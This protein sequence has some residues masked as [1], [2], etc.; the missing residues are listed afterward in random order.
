[1]KPITHHFLALPIFIAC[2]LASTAFAQGTRADYER[3][4]S[5]TRRT[6]GKLFKES[7]APHWLP[8]NNAFWYRNDLAGGAR[9]FILVEAAKG[10]RRP[11]FD[12]ARLATA[13]AAASGREVKS[14]RLPFDALEFGGGRDTVSFH[15]FGK[16]WRCVLAK[17]EVTAAPPAPAAPLPPPSSGDKPRVSRAST[18][19]TSLTFVNQTAGEI[20]LFWID[21][22]GQRRSYGR[23]PA[24]ERRDQHS[25]IGHVWRVETHDGQL[26]GV[27]AAGAKGREAII[28]PAIAAAAAVATTPAAPAKPR[29]ADT[30]PDGRWQAFIKN[31]NL[32]ARVLETKEEFALTTDG[33]AED[34]YEAR[35]HWSPDS[36]RLA[37][38]QIRKGEER[39]IT[40]VESSPKE[41]LQP[42]LH[43]LNYAKP[44]DRIAQPRPRLFDL[45]NRKAIAIADTLFPNPF[46]LHELH[47]SPDSRWF[48][49]SYNQRGHQVYRIV[50]IDA[51]TGAARALVNEE[52]A[53]FFAYSAKRH[54]HWLDA[55]GELIWMSERDGWNHLYRYETATGRVK[56]AITRGEWVVRGVERVDAERGQVWFRA[57]G[58]RPG[59]DPYQVHLCRVN[60][61]GSG[62]TVLTE[63]D[64]NHDWQF[65]PDHRFVLDRWSRVDQ[66]PVHELRD[67]ESGRLLCELE[68]ADAS[69]LYKTGWRAPERFVAKGRDGA[70]DIFGIIIRPA[71]FD[72][73]KKYPVIEEIYAGPHGA[74]VPKTFGRNLRPSG[75]AELGFILVRSD[76]MGTN[77]RSKQFHDV[78][79]KNLGDSGFPDRIAW[80]KA[81]AAKHPELDLTRVGIYG[82]SAGGQSTARALFAHGD[83][84]RVGVADCGCHD[85]R[86]DKIWWNEQWMGWPVGPHYA[87]QSNV[88]G[89]KNLVG[90]LLLIVGELDKNVDPSSTMQVVNALIKADKDFDLLV[91]PGGGHGIAESPYGSRRRVDFFVRHL[92]GVEPRSQP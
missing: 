70:T 87:E 42:K 65:S 58:I 69:E 12:H 23:V 68:R 40:L 91:V 6:E 75:M 67:A 24:G 16:P 89:A 3:A 39:Q 81:A 62:L 71:N 1:M 73:T 83:F 27:F 26:L 54:L 14:E 74:F 72:P 33:A 60:F 49:F 28:T 64:G 63:G 56:N 50:A 35:F 44:G 22:S 18:E 9:E 55:T 13:L 45:P 82:G 31:H 47:W 25:F 66:P 8:G 76:G 88:T 38:R 59:Q 57:G 92:L 2:F 80:L 84:Y 21:L 46:E 48:A 85:N 30:S 15:A 29:A 11:A 32:H 36:R 78:C 37:V 90:K 61:D 4:A 19:E 51:D 41:Q 17:Y 86:M 34:A 79:W 7:L 52:C 43:E 53:T 20:A 10:E 5:L 77:W